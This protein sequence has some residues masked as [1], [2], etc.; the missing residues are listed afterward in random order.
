[1]GIRAIGAAPKHRINDQI[2]DKEVRLVGDNVESAIVSIE[3]ARG[4]ADELELDLVLINDQAK[5]A[6]AKIM[7]YKKFIF[8]STKKVKT[9]KS[10]PMKEM[11][12][13]PNIGDNDFEFKLNHVKNFLERGHKVKAYVIFKGREMSFKT[14]GEEILLRL[15]VGI[16]DVGVP[17]GLPKFEGRKCI[18]IFKP[19]K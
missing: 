15:S 11:R 17:E 7:D 9:P 16:E 2:R 4:R 6:I 8:E 12:Y 19:K 13:T 10:K 14:Q 3:V 5:P 1:M 18:I